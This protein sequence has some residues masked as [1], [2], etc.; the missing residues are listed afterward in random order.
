MSS[1]PMRVVTLG[2]VVFGGLS[3]DDDGCAFD[4]TGFWGVGDRLDEQ[5]IY[6]GE[7]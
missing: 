7:R 4:R 3:G 5:G 1:L 2:L 6:T